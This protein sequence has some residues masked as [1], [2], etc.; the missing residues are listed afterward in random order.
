MKKLLISALSCLLIIS[1][2]SSCEKKQNDG[3]D[4][5]KK[6]FNI[7][8][9]N[10]ESFSAQVTV[11]PADM[12]MNYL[13]GAMPSAEY[14]VD[15]ITSRFTKEFFDNILKLQEMVYDK[16]YYYADLFYVGKAER[17]FDEL[18]ANTEYTVFAVGI[19]T[20]SFK[21]TTP[22]ETVTFRTLEFAVKGKKEIT[23]DNLDYVDYV[24]K[25]GWWQ[26]FGESAVKDNQFY[27]LTVSP[28]ETDKAAG[29]YTLED[30]DAD[31]T[32]L[33]HY[34]INGKDTTV[35]NIS[36][37]TG[38]F[39]LKETPEGATL[40]ATVVG[41]DGYQ[42]SI[43]ATGISSSD[44]VEIIGEEELTFTN[45]DFINAVEDEGWWQIQGDLQI[46]DNQYVF[47]S[48][49]PELTETVTGTYTMDDMDSRYTLLAYYAVNGNDT[50][51]SAYVDFVDG[52]F[53]VTETETGATME[54]I[55][56]GDDGYQYTIHATAILK[57]NGN[58]APARRHVT[59]RRS[60]ALG[61]KKAK[62]QKH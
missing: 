24:Q 59:V 40:E 41:S 6:N 23:F 20:V 1:V 2:F 12:S 42:Y 49:S 10:V 16:K 55:A 62:F 9:S 18:N 28:V 52:Q 57:E 31:Y 54:A 47:M 4:G 19:D 27:Y 11:T 36:F 50:T 13:F 33:K 8:C 30:M 38:E 46:A 39:E 60:K 7:E 45:I 61:V 48:V 26:I 5:T 21:L 32:F 35:E 56:V 43:H 29:V 51:V 17:L 25:G 44:D 58:Y 22:V 53:Q 34:T 15:S 14:N 37:V 3:P